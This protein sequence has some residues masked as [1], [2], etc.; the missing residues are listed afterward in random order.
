MGIQNEA[1]ERQKELYE[2]VT[3]THMLSLFILISVF[4]FNEKLFTKD[5]YPIIN[6]RSLILVSLIGFVIVL[7]Y[8]QRNLSTVLSRRSFSWV[9]LAYAALPLFMAALT[10][11]TAREGHV[12][13]E[14]VLLLPILVAASIMGKPAGLIMASI[15]AAL[16]AAYRTFYLFQEPLEVLESGVILIG[17]MYVVGWFIGGIASMESLYRKRLTDLAN[18]DP[19]TRLYNH[20]YFQE[21]LQEYLPQASKEKPLSLIFMDLDYF[22]HYND[23]FGHLAGDQVLS[24]IGAILKETVG[25]IGF[26]ARYGGDEFMVVLPACDSGR[27][28]E[29]A[30][31]IRERMKT[32]HF[33]GEEHQPGG[34]ITLSC[35]VVTY[36]THAST[37]RELVKYADQALYRAKCLNKNKVE[38]YFSV[39]DDLELEEDEKD[40]FNSIRTLVSVINSKDRYT[41]GHSERVTDY[42]TRLAKKMGLSR[43]EIRLL[44]YAAFL[45]D[46]GKIE[47][48]R[49]ILNKPGP[50][51]L[52][53]WRILR[54]HPLWGSDIVKSVTKLQPIATAIL[55]HHENYDGS[56]YPEGI[57]GADIP[58]P[59]R[60]IRIA[61]SFDAMTSYRPYRR[62]MSWEEAANE[63][64]RCAGTVFD[65]VV[66][67]LFIEI[68]EEEDCLLCSKPP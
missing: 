46:I 47:I 9:D 34:K 10:L 61:D 5:I 3:I 21:K 37:A 28:I 25:E 29:I 2:Y 68:L 44:K 11:F 39:F 38:L 22:K 42:S 57:R 41:Y 67:R 20:R 27:A 62:K 56:G 58:L 64:E 31:K 19:L 17:L 50:L 30:E 48:D 8:N 36:P 15:C 32:E 45:H 18:T 49:S 53:E 51:D 1:D 16:L 65:P 59:A 12:Y 23:G 66:A 13:V 4:V 54:Q 6:I 40:L 24:A 60:I 26:A 55:Y 52:E 43:E 63:I 7:L 14:A 33:P 35:G